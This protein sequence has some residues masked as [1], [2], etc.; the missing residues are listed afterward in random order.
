LRAMCIA[1]CL[2]LVACRASLR[3]PASD[4]MPILHGTRNRQDFILDGAGRQAKENL[5]WGWNKV[6]V[7]LAKQA[8][9]LPR[10][11]S[12]IEKVRKMCRLWLQTVALDK[13]ITCLP[14]P[15]VMRVELPEVWRALC[16][17]HYRYRPDESAHT[18]S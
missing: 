13:E 4:E 7:V 2:L 9:L 12:S 5:I 15:D 14:S 8:A 17:C 1:S 18:V 11:R 6:F 16:V 10:R 3:F